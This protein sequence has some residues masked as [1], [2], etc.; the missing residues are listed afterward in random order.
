MSISISAPPPAAVT[1][2]EASRAPAK[3]EARPL[4]EKTEKQEEAP[5]VAVAGLKKAEYD[6]PPDHVLIIDPGALR[7]EG[8]VSLERAP[9]KDAPGSLLDVTY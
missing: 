6:V 8:R 3:V 9:P 5:R 7:G 2:A 1:Q 4:P